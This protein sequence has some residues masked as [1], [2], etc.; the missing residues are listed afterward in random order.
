MLNAALK[1]GANTTRACLHPLQTP[2]TSAHTYITHTFIEPK[3]AGCQKGS[4]C[5]GTGR[6]IKLAV[7][8]S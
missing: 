8:R 3:L 2:L 7:L 4:G 5:H 1:V 6:D